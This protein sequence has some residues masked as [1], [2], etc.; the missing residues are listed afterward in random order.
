MAASVGDILNITK[1]ICSLFKSFKGARE[2]IKEVGAET[3]ELHQYMNQLKSLLD[4]RESALKRKSPTSHRN[5]VSLLEKIEIDASN[6]LDIL[7]Q[8]K[9]S[10]FTGHAFWQFTSNPEALTGSTQRI[11]EGRRKVAE[12]VQLFQAE[13]QQQQ[14]KIQQHQLKLLKD[15]PARLARASKSQSPQPKSILFVDS[16]DDGPAVIAAFYT[17]L[18]RQWTTRA[19]NNWPVGL[20]RSAGVRLPASGAVR[21]AQKA[22]GIGTSAMVGKRPSSEVT[23]AL[24]DNTYFNY[25]YK[26][27]I[28]DEATAYKAQAL[29]QDCVTYDYVITF[30]DTATRE[31]QKVVNHLGKSGQA[32]AMSGKLVPLAKYHSSPSIREI[33]WRNAQGDTKQRY[34]TV[35]NQIKQAFKD[36]LKQELGWQ[37]PPN[38]ELGH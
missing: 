19:G 29:E 25:E 32:K 28:R 10:G 7:N 35:V 4:D 22:L 24:F 13:V 18:V 12:W 20:V 2:Q 9:T 34:R 21:S 3:Q 14:G 38:E 6:L 27:K 8:Y 26:A 23:T 33:S 1:E 16:L 31:L 37:Q 36:F 15:L 11:R 30:D 5:L 17:K